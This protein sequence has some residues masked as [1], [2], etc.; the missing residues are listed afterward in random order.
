MAKNTRACRKWAILAIVFCAVAAAGVYFFLDSLS[1]YSREEIEATVQAAEALTSVHGAEARQVIESHVLKMGSLE[2]WR[3]PDIRKDL[4]TERQFTDLSEFLAPDPE[5][6]QITAS[7]SV[8]HVRVVE[9]SP[10]RFEAIACLTTVYEEINATDE[11]VLRVSPESE[12]CAIYVF[13]S[14]EGN[15]KLAA[16]FDTTDPNHID[17]DWGFLPD[18]IKEEIGE[19]P[20]DPY[21]YRERH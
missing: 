7:A 4:V 19:L 10:E 17:R 11:S 9:Y 3:N 18:W 1:E 14:D 6:F 12:H 2:A 8:D 13:V 15:W 20:Y 21:M 16:S 5:S